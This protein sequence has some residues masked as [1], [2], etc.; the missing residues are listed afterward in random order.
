MYD[1]N[2]AARVIEHTLTSDT[3]LMAL[4]EGVIEDIWSKDE[5]VPDDAFPFVRFTIITQDDEYYNGQVR[6]TTNQSVLIHGVQ[7]FENNGSYGGTLGTIADRIDALLH[8][9]TIT[10]YDTDDSTE[11]GQAYIYR[12]SPIRERFIDG[13]IEYR[14]LGGI[15][16]ISTNEH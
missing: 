7:K 8:K 5:N 6:A 14:Y 10:I 4:I 11:I 12:E 16:Q 13:S 1:G 15:Y 2:F 9:Q 3:T